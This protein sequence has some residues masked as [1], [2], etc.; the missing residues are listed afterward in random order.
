[1]S[2]EA[3]AQEQTTTG[4]HRSL[5]A[6]H[7]TMIA[8]G[9]AIGTGLFVA[10]GASVA[11]AGPGGAVV[12]YLVIG[13]MV[14]FLMSSLGEMGAYMPESGSFTLYSER[15]VDPAFGFAQGWNYWFNWAVTIA[16]ELVAAQ[17]VMAFWFPDVPGYWWSALFLTIFVL[18]N[19]FSVK[20]FGEG[21]YWFSM[22]KVAA[23]VVFLLASVFMLLGV[24]GKGPAPGLSN[25]T[26]GEAPFVGGL[27]AIIGV[28]MIAGFSYQ[29]TELI[30][31]TAGEAEHPEKTIP[32]AIRQVFWRILIFYVLSILMIGLLLPYNDP[33]LLRSNV[34][35]IAVSPFTLVLEKSGV[36]AAASIMNAVILTAILSAGNS[37]M[38]ASTRTLYS[39]A[40]D[41]QAPKVFAKLS[42]NGIPIYALLMTTVVGALCFF[43]SLVGDQVIYLWLLNLSGLCGFLAWLGI[44]ISH[45]RFRKGFIAQGRSLSELPYRARFFPFGPLFAFSLCL[46]IVLGQN[47][48]AFFEAN[49]N[50]NGIIATYIGLPLFLLVWLVYRIK[51]KTRFVRIDEMQ[52]P[53]RVEPARKAD[54]S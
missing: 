14:Y 12:A 53:P 36:M 10:S 42:K 9:G 44:A 5:Q 30:G 6:R 8:I 45:Y 20:S 54:D 43:T 41:G 11:Q 35:D 3:G 23:V 24:L 50:W 16:V 34:K 32:K 1:M 37:G 49:I 28:A 46:F 7:L 51:H 4:L 33:L 47:Y 27:G 52:F 17:I 15:F 22:V 26:M 29:G 18:L 38:Y 21:E 2:S 31:I 40:L 13:I 48:E 39:M 25:F 19:A